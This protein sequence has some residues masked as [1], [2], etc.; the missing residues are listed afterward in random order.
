M[1]QT[2]G[3]FVSALFICNVTSDVFGQL[4]TTGEEP[5]G[6]VNL[7]ARATEFGFS[8]DFHGLYG[9]HDDFPA[10]QNS[11]SRMVEW[12]FAAGE[13]QTV[14][15]VMPRPPDPP[16]EEAGVAF[17]EPG[18]TAPFSSNCGFFSAFHIS[19]VTADRF[20]M[21]S[22]GS[23]FRT[24]SQAGPD[25]PLLVDRKFFYPD[26]NDPYPDIHLRMPTHYDAELQ[27][28]D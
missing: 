8:A 15:P 9:W 5:R 10:D 2:N 25:V 21:N 13:F 1:A 26:S 24:Q 20:V 14:G 3:P 27:Y 19:R 16:A 11:I 18:C 28:F 17:C 6:M 23:S 7:V 4:I 22:I 12:N